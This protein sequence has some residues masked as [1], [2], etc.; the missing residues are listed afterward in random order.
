MMLLREADRAFGLVIVW[1]HVG[2]AAQQEENIA[3]VSAVVGAF[4]VATTVGYVLR[5]RRVAAAG[6]PALQ[7]RRVPFARCGP[8]SAAT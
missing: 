8:V 5:Q 1:A 4:I 2:I 6:S 7:R 3:V